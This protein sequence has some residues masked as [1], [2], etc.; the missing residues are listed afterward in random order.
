MVTKRAQLSILL[1]EQDLCVSGIGPFLEHATNVSIMPREES[2][3]V[4]FL[5][6]LTKP[7]FEYSFFVGFKY[8][9][10]PK[11]SRTFL[12]KIQQAF[13]YQNLAEFSSPN[14]SRFS[15]PAFP[16]QNLAEFSLP[17][18]QKKRAI[19]NFFFLPLFSTMG[20]TSFSI[21]RIVHIFKCVHFRCFQRLDFPQCQKNHHFSY[22]ITISPMLVKSSL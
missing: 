20:K 21:S 6:L 4:V 9:C 19:V 16:Y 15:L 13:P 14:F 5:T 18:Y 10:S 8:V 22:K 12:T 3:K 7:G 17:N 1:Q 11:F 2:R